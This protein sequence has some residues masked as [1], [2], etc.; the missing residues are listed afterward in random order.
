MADSEFS[1][2]VSLDPGLPTTCDGICPHLDVLIFF[3]CAGIGPIQGQAH[4][5]LRYVPEQVPYAAERFRNET[6]RL[7][8]VLDKRLAGSPFIA[9]SDYSI[10]DIALY[11]WVAYHPWAGQ[12]ISD[13]LALRAWCDL[14]GERPAVQLGLSY[15]PKD[16]SQLLASA[17]HVRR[18]VAA[19]TLDR[20]DESSSAGGVA[21]GARL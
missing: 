6:R 7:Y 15:N 2:R 20:V 9:G 19:T 4:A 12:D 17:D 5:F 3:Q 14:V 8:E 10:A 13:L 18:T 21:G 1:L 11:P 16:L